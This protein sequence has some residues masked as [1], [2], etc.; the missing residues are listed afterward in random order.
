MA[1][2]VARAPGRYD[3]TG[4]LTFSAEPPRAVWSAR[5]NPSEGA[6]VLDLGGLQ[7]VDS[8]ALALLL[9]WERQARAGGFR[10]VVTA[11]P[12]RLKAL[13]QVTGLGA[14]FADAA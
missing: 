3:L 6:V 1:E 4:D 11:V 5:L 8:V 12:P 7:S 13:I 14:L 10:L 2:L 9:E